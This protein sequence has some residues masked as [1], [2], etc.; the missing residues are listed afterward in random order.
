MIASEDF[1]SIT[2]AAVF[3]ILVKSKRYLLCCF[4]SNQQVNGHCIGV[5]L[6]NACVKHVNINMCCRGKTRHSKIRGI[7]H[8]GRDVMKRLCRG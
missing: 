7:L 1:C 8:N 2:A 6:Q 5:W 4:S 3:A